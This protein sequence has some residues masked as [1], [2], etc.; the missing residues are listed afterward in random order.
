MLAF[1]P[2]Y[3]LLDECANEEE[4]GFQKLYTSIACLYIA[5]KLQNRVDQFSCSFDYFQSLT[6][7]CKSYATLME[8]YQ[9]AED[10]FVWDE[11]WYK[12]LE[13]YIL[14]QIGF[15]F[16]KVTPACS[17]QLVFSWAILNGAAISKS[18]WCA[19]NKL[20]SQLTCLAFQSK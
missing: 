4:P 5:A 6:R 11:G 8:L 18:L 17:T 16:P 13:Q 3:L 12:Q 10:E 2:S 15:R 19:L 20:A 7:Q 14:Q 1:K 9:L